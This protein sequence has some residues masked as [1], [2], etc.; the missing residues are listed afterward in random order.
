MSSIVIFSP[1]RFSLYT[2]CV[3]ELLRRNHVNIQA[4]VVRRLL[5]PARFLSE[6]SRDGSRL[7]KKVW[8]KLVLRQ[9]AYPTEAGETIVSLMKSEIITFTKVEDFKK[10]FQ[11][12]VLY[13]SDLNDAA[14]INTLKELNPELVVFTGGGLLRNRVL[15]NSGAGVLNCHMGVLPQYRGMDVV[16][17]ALLE[18]NLHQVGATVHFMDPGVDTGDILQVQ[19]VSVEPGEGI[20]HLRDRI[21]PLMVHLMVQTCI[22]YIGGK[23]KRMPQ[24]F[25]EGRQYFVMHPRLMRE[26]GRKMEVRI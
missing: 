20:S 16:E 2:I 19:Q 3:T 11:I 6:F 1:S 12:P 7:L 18:G 10:H 24:K 17:W 4:I 15:E 25:A 8:K 22:D 9:K 14:V 23:L 13:C 5:N 26:A 21:E